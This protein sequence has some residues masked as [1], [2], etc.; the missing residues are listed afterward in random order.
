MSRGIPLGIPARHLNLHLSIPTPIAASYLMMTSSNG[1]IFCVTGPL[2]GG[3][4]GYRWI[5][6][7]KASDAEVWGFL[8][9]APEEVVEKNNRDAGDLRRHCAHYDVTL[10][11]SD[12]SRTA[13]YGCRCWTDVDPTLRRRTQLSLEKKRL[14]IVWRL[15]SVLA[16]PVTCV[17]T[18]C[19]TAYS[20][21]FKEDIK[22]LYH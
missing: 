9:S 10:M 16:S 22:A 17:P 19:S 12:S 13:L 8:R 14:T 5:P 6:H 3:F 18:L 2:R 4:T 1:N 7:T 20:R 15:M 11:F 21:K